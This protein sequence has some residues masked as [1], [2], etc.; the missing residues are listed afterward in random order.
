MTKMKKR[1]QASN[2]EVAA[3][4]SCLFVLLKTLLV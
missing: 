1:G 4:Q 2:N 3:E